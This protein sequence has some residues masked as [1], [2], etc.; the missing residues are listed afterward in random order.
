VGSE[1]ERAGTGR[2]ERGASAGSGIRNWTGETT[3]AG[4]TEQSRMG[5]AAGPRWQWQGVNMVGPG[6]RGRAGKRGCGCRESMGLAVIDS[7]GVGGG[8]RRSGVNGGRGRRRVG[9]GAWAPLG[10]LR[11]SL[12]AGFDRRSSKLPEEVSFSLFYFSLSISIHTAF[13]F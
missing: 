13:P 1:G 3:A 6:C 10:R 12:A 2:R 11:P 7:S 8:V 4:G 9:T 5:N